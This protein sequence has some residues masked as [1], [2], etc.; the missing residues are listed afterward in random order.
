MLRF[1]RNPRRTANS[2]CTL[3]GHVW[4]IAPVLYVLEFDNWLHSGLTVTDPGRIEHVRNTISSP[5]DK[6][7]QLKTALFCEWYD[8]TEGHRITRKKKRWRKIQRETRDNERLTLQWSVNNFSF[9]PD[10]HL[11]IVRRL[12]KKKRNNQFTKENNTVLLLRERNEF[13]NYL[14]INSAASRYKWTYAKTKQGNKLG[15]FF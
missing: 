15:S 6:Q 8:R 11:S 13:S 14:R 1:W 5:R 12:R 4:K 9:M 2:A 3:F 7:M 10:E